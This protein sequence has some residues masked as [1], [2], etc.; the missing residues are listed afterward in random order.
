MDYRKKFGFD[1][2]NGSKLWYDDYYK[3]YYR[4]NSER[5]HYDIYNSIKQ[6]SDNHKIRI[7]VNCDDRVT[8]NDIDDKTRCNNEESVSGASVS[9]V[10]IDDTNDVTCEQ[11]NSTERPLNSIVETTKKNFNQ[12]H[13]HNKRYNEKAIDVP[14]EFEKR[15]YELAKKSELSPFVRNIQPSSQVYL[16][17]HYNSIEFFLFLQFHYSI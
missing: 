3:D 1:N 13:C 17:H 10:E 6:T 15:A 9:I 2:K 4:Y 12:I 5:I 11:N 14:E 8:Q 7:Q 16:L